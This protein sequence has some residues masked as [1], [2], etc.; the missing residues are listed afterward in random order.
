[1]SEYKFKVGDKVRVPAQDNA[2]RTIV[3]TDRKLGVS[4]YNIVLDR[5][6]MYTDEDGDEGENC[7]YYSARELELIQP[8][9]KFKVGDKVRLN[10]KSWGFTDDGMSLEDV[11]EVRM[12]GNSP[13][14]TGF[15]GFPGGYWDSEDSFDLVTEQVEEPQSTT[16]GIYTGMSAY[17]ANQLA[18]PLNFNELA[19]AYGQVISKPSNKENKK[20]TPKHYRVKQDLPDLQAGAILSNSQGDYQ[21]ISDLWNTKALDKVKTTTAWPTDLVEEAS[22][23]FE[24]VYDVTVLGK[25]KY[26]VK[27]AAQKAYSE[28][29]KSK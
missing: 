12:I 8:V 26:L 14:V 28:L 2:E 1:M 11:G 27:D 5:P 15:K 18:S 21:P 29:H 3:Q 4:P 13:K 17:Y 24:R 6:I 25:V 7:N 19:A 9:Y 16:E 22:D 23:W 10:K 20:M